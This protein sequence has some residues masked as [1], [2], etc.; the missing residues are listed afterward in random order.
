MDTTTAN[1]LEDKETKG[2]NR[3]QTD[4]SM[5]TEKDTEWYLYMCTNA[6]C[7]VNTTCHTTLSSKVTE[8]DLAGA[9]YSAV[10]YSVAGSSV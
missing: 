1:A 5:W 8:C 2:Q 7:Y 3:G 9:R 4:P 6:D 10:A